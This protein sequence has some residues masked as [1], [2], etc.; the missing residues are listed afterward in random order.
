MR[1]ALKPGGRVAFVCWRGMA[2]N[3]WMRL[4]IGAIKDILAPMTP[5]GP[6]APRPFSFGDPGRV[7]SILTKAGFTDVAIEPF[8]ASVPFGEGDTRDA[9]LNDTV[10]MTPYVGPLAFHP[11]TG[12]AVQRVEGN[13]FRRGGRSVKRNRTS[14]HSEFDEASPIRSRGDHDCNTPDTTNAIQAHQH[15]FVPSQNELFFNDLGL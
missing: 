15:A 2:E 8:E 5:P 4:P 13:P 12:L 6:E 14:D 11:V 7:A 1:R 10:N 9:A 3:D